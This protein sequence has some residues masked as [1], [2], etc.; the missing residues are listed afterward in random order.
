MPQDGYRPNDA[1]APLTKAGPTALRAGGRASCAS[2]GPCVPRMGL[3]RGQCHSDPS[4][5]DSAVPVPHRYR[6][7]RWTRLTAPVWF[8]HLD[9]RLADAEV[10]GRGWLGP[11]ALRDG[12]GGRLRYKQHASEPVGLRRTEA[13][14]SRRCDAGDSVSR[15]LKRMQCVRLT[16]S[17]TSDSSVRRQAPVVVSVTLAGVLDRLGGDD[18]HQLV[19]EF[20]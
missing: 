1:Y 17:R 15:L 7:P 14:H 19:Y 20:R 18:L 5:D 3:S 2:R 16:R 9:Q 11:A 6:C 4:P 8:S 13:T 12:D 10:D